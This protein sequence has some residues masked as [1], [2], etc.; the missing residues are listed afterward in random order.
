MEENFKPNIS[1]NKGKE[2]NHR[3]TMDFI[4]SGAIKYLLVRYLKL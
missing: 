1:G 4:N 3:P 2:D